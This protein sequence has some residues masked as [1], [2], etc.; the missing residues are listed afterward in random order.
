MCTKEYYPALKRKGIL[1]YHNMDEHSRHYTKW[2]EAV[3]KG[4][5]L[6]YWTYILKI[7]KNHTDR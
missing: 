2:N 7:V 6:H 5:V 3:T 1:T 4:Q